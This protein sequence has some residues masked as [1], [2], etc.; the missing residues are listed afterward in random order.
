MART[1]SGHLFVI[2]G[3][4]DKHQGR[5]I[6]RQ[7]VESAGGADA[8]I[9]VVATASSVPEEVLALYEEAF[10]ALDVQ[11]VELVYHEHR[12]DADGPAAIATLEG[13]TGVYF[14]GGDQLRLVSVI[15]G[16]AFAALLHK[17]VREGLHVG[18]TSAGAAAMSAVMIARGNRRAAPRLSSIR[19]S[20]GLGI[21]ERVIIDQHFQE[22]GRLGRL[23]A[24][25][26]RNPYLL[27]FGIDEDTAFIVDPAGEVSVLGS[28]TLTIVDGGGIVHSNVPDVAEGQPLAFA[29][30]GLHVLAE[31]WGFNI[32]DRTLHLPGGARMPVGGPPMVAELVESGGTS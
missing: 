22:R 27:G 12:L 9:L 15:G 2:G 1:H 28:G 26:L 10:K 17:R 13:A 25:V 6:L 18:G 32:F 16:T 3:A 20:P 24:A 19:L 4:E 14:T 31:G 29:G 5:L 21:I 23:V 11:H 8:R 30:I 7:F